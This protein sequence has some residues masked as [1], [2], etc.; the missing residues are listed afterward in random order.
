MR[1]V[2]CINAYQEEKQLPGCLDA[3]RPLVD[4]VVVVDGR[5]SD[6]TGYSE[7][8]GG[9]STDGTLDA[10]RAAG[11]TIIEAPG[12]N[13]WEN[14][15]VKRTAYLRACREGDYVL[16]VDADERVEGA[17]DR[18]RLAQRAD[19]TVQHYRTEQ[20]EL[21]RA[22]RH[23]EDESRLLGCL[24]LHRL[25][26]WRPGIRYEGTHHVVHVGETM[27]HPLPMQADEATRFPG[28]RMRHER[29]NDWPRTVRKCR[30][31]QILAASEKPYRQRMAL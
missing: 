10:A 12:G 14:E 21:N 30:Y 27:I 17:V 7:D 23:G 20:Y 2:A 28:L 25:F 16:V 9:A 29:R 13:P 1:I 3:L 6:F 22:R 11:A 4:R 26:A 31:Y 19:W 24:W 5:Y 8:G 15:I 18:E